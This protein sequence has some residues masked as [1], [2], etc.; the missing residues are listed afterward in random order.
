MVI[1]R[2][3]E[4]YIGEYA[5]GKSENAINRAIELA[6]QGRTVTL[7]DLDLVEPFYTL[8]PIQDELSRLDIDVVAW[9]TNETMGLG[10]AGNVLKPEMKW[11]LR[12]E[13]DIIMDIG[14]GIEGSKTLNLVEGALEDPDLRIIGVINI[15]RPMT[16]TVEDIVE[17]VRDMQPVHAL[18][19]N[20][21]LGDETTLE[22]IKEGS[23]RVSQAARELGIPVVATTVDES[24]KSA[25]PQ[26]TDWLGNPIRTLKRFMPRAFW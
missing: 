19:N 12:R 4:G 18:L 20:T 3:V 21:H 1:Q 5:S 2:I 10:E 23:E 7:V 17:H 8:R 16:Y 11:V 22:V 24:L 13:G 14:Y 26:G 6:K 25:F 15:S 9:H